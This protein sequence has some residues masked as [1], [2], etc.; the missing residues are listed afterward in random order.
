MV[1]LRGLIGILTNIDNRLANWHSR[2][3]VEKRERRDRRIRKER[4]RKLHSFEPQRERCFVMR[5]T[6]GY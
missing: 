6:L 3:A 5:R 4:W 2:R 1:S